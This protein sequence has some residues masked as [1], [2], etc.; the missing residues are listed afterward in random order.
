MAKRD[1]LT[2]MMHFDFIG[3]EISE[4]DLRVMGVFGAMR[5]G[6][7]IEQALSKYSL[8]KEEYLNNID[9]VLSQ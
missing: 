3:D 9:R 7:S 2:T 5:G 8:T 1:E 4:F 6:L